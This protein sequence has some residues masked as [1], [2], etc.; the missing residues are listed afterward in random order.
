MESSDICRIARSS[1]GMTQE[2]WAEA[3]GV[4]PEAVRQ[5]E[6]GKIRPAD[7]VVLNMATVAAMPVICYWHMLNKSSVA[8]ELLPE[9]ADV[10]LP[11][12]AIQLLRRMQAF[13]RAGRLDALLAIAEDGVIDDREAPEFQAIVSELR[14][15]V[16]AAMQVNLCRAEEPRHGKNQ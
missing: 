1:A 15:L 8:A 6:G 14:A 16:A 7:D 10:P 4:T 5:Y 9:V 3:L 12:A 11:Q 13:Q 2:R